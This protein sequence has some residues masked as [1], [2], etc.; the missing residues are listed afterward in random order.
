MPDVIIDGIKM[1]Y[2]TVN[3]QTGDKSLILIHG[4]GGDSL[5]FEKILV[6]LPPA[7]KGY[8][9]DLPGHGQSEG[10]PCSDI[11]EYAEKVSSFIKVVNPTRPRYLL[12]HSMGGAVALLT[13]LEQPDLIESVVVIGSGARLKVSPQFLEQLAKGELSPEFLSL[14]FAED[15][16]SAIKEEFLKRAAEVPVSTY[17]RDF[18]ACNRFDISQRLGELRVPLYILVGSEDR[19]TPVKMSLSLNQ[20]VFSSSLTVIENGGHFVMLEKPD[21]VLRSILQFIS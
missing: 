6:A 21:E 16:P 11:M 1:H 10:D 4:A 2:L 15:T 13:A 3:E 14:G 20:S 8:A 12:G 9:L 18:T 19:L 7:V 5:V 17:A